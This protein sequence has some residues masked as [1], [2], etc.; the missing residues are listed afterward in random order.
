[1]RTMSL[2]FREFLS[3]FHL[4]LS[5]IH[6]KYSL[7]KRRQKWLA[8][9]WA[10][11]HLFLLQISGSKKTPEGMFGLA[12]P[13]RKWFGVIASK[14]SGLSL[15]DVRGRLFNIDST[16]ASRVFK[17]SELTHCLPSICRRIVSVDRTILSHTPSKWGANGG[18]NFHWIPFRNKSSWICSWFHNLRQCLSSLLAPTKLVPLSDT[19]CCG[20]PPSGSPQTGEEPVWKHQC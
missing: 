20:V 13:M 16:S 4:L 2:C 14:S 1:M 19:I 11:L 12:R 10:C 18:L 15:T 9:T 7:V 3:W 8:W 5:V 6:G 17:V